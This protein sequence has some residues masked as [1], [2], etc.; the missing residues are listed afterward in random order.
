MAP[1]APQ[2]PATASGAAPSVTGAAEAAQAGPSAVGRP[3]VG[4]PAPKP[5]DPKLIAEANAF[6]VRGQKAFQRGQYEEAEAQLKQ[7]LTLYPFLAQANLT[8]GKIFLLRGA[9]NKDYALIESARLMFEM[10][11]TL[12]P[13]LTEPAVLLDLFKGPGGD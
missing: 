2:A 11:R 1:M 10:A 5:I 8:L 7:A 3:P 6:V 13:Q 4:P 9:A 12:D